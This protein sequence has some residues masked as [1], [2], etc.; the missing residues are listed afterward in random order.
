MRCLRPSLQVVETSRLNLFFRR[1]AVNTLGVLVA[2]NVVNGIQ[3]DSFAGL[4]VAS[5]LLGIF[6]ATL[7][8]LLIIFTLPLVVVTFGLFT[9]IINA[10]LV[11]VIGHV[12]TSF[13]VAGFWPAFWAGL[14]ISLVSHLANWMI[15]PDKPVK[16]PTPPRP[17]SDTGSGP[18]IDV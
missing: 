3:Y 10:L 12:V 7:R 6:N 16:P 11:F 4:L 2:A 1:W 17:P 8:P 15:G 18:V 13:H 9:L 5:L 14:V